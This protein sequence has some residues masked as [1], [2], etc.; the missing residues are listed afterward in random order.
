[1]YLVDRFHMSVSRE[2]LFVAWVAV[3][4]VAAN[5]GIVVWLARRLN[6]RQTAARA[7]AVLAV[8]MR[9]SWSHTPR[10]RSNRTGA[11]PLPCGTTLSCRASTDPMLTASSGSTHIC[12]RGSGW[13]ASPPACGISA[14]GIALIA[15]VVPNILVPE[16]ALADITSVAT[17]ALLGK[18]VMIV[19]AHLRFRHLLAAARRH[20]GSFGRPASQDCSS[21]RE[22]P[23]TYGRLGH[24]GGR[25]SPRRK[26]SPHAQRTGGLAVTGCFDRERDKCAR[27]TAQGG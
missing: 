24:R 9:R 10:A 21:R 6:A 3:P 12:F 25:L 19:I 23:T 14:C 4:I 1:M 27:V 13:H 17:V 18:W 11:A 5:L 15:G 8:A 20:G 16:P 7:A 2:S 22:R 26:L